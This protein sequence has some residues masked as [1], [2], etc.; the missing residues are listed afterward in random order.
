MSQSQA[1]ASSMVKKV[2]RGSLAS[3]QSSPRAIICLKPSS[4][5]AAL[6]RGG[7]ALGGEAGRAAFGNPLTQERQGL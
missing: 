2:R 7:A 1:S 3:S 6:A 4:R 5:T